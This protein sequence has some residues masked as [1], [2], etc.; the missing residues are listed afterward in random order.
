MCLSEYLGR[1]AAEKPEERRHS[2]D[3]ISLEMSG[4]VLDARIVRPALI[5]RIAWLSP[6]R[7]CWFKS[8]AFRNYHYST[9]NNMRGIDDA[10]LAA[11]VED[12]I[13]SKEPD[14]GISDSD[15]ATD[16]KLAL[17]RTA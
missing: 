8:N 17:L 15:D 4:S 2:L 14:H 3:V 16:R 10:T 1:L 11:L 6:T 5:R 12:G 7:H 13:K 9:T